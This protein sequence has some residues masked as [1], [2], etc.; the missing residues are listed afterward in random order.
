MMDS[1]NKTPQRNEIIDM[2]AKHI[3]SERIINN[4]HRGDIVEMMVLAALGDEWTF[5]GLGWHPWDLQR[6]TGG[7]R[8]RIQ[9]KQCAALQIWGTTKNLML[10]FGWKKKAPEYFFR[11]NP[12]EEIEAEGWF[13]DVFVFGL[14]LETDMVRADQVDPAQWKFLVIPTCDLRPGQDSMHLTEA[15]KKWSPVA[16]L[17]L[18]QT[19]EHAIAKNNATIRE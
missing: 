9:V 4:S 3:Y 16:W 10:K 8:V 11:D 12:G 2:V 14:H 18:F 19:V 6:G 5:V 1:L 17:E 13:C 15:L 7:K